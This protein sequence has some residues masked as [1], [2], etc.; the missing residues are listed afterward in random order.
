[1]NTTRL[2]EF[3]LVNSSPV[4]L[5]R[6][7]IVLFCV[8]VQRESC[9][10]LWRVAAASEGASPSLLRGQDLNPGARNLEWFSAL[11][12]S[13]LPLAERQIELAICL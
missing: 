5:C 9:A 10:D 4:V 13:E 11:Q 2:K 7:C 1:M 3:V 8:V 6:T 12:E